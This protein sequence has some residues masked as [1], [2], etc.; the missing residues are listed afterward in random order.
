MVLALVVTAAASLVL[1]FAPGIP[2]GLGKSML[3][4]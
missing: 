3:A 4:R 1:F 2:L